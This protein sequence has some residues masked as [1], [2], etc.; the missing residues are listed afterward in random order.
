[1]SAPSLTLYGREGCHLCADML[2]DLQPYAERFGVH[3]EIV[4]VDSDAALAQRFGPQVP[5]LALGD[6]VI[7]HYFLDP[8][9]LQDTLTRNTASPDAP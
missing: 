1:M 5:V 3:V 6:R 4:D 9:A 2:A 8:G 7:C